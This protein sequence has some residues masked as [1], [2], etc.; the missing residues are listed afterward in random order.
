MIPS[1]FLSNFWQKTQH[2]CKWNL[3]KICLHIKNCIAYSKLAC[4]KNWKHFVQ[5]VL[6][7]GAT[8]T[9]MA[10]SKS[11]VKVILERARKF[12]KQNRFTLVVLKV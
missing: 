7:Y 3:F 8:D 11:L 5:P 1:C 4:I 9:C 10:R 6:S 12:R 2:T